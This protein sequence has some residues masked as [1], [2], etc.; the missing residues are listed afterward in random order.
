MFTVRISVGRAFCAAICSFAPLL[1]SAQ[2]A[3]VQGPVGQV[4]DADVMAD[5]ATR[6]SDTA[7][8]TVLSR[9]DNVGQLASN[10]YVQRAMAV[11]AERRGLTAGRESAAAL[12]LAREKAMADLYLAEFDKNHQPSEA[13][14]LAYAQSTY[15]AV[16][17]K[18]LD[19]PERTRVRHILL[20]QKSPETRARIEQILSDARAGKDFAQLAKD[21]SEDTGS[22]AQGGDI[23]FVT[24]G[25]TVVPFEEAMKGLKTPGD[26]SDVVE[27]QFGYHII[28]LEERRSAG[29]RGFDEVREQLLMQ[30]RT[31]LLR[32]A[33][34]KEA[35]RL[36][37]GMKVN[38]AAVNTFSSKF[39]PSD[40]IR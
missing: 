15:R 1:V 24:E 21:N 12:A 19:A 26:L 13:A 22:V 31:A 7:R 29:K 8:A 40:S 20:K 34:A 37:E 17:G 33:R 25:S 4:T 3:L 36:Q 6:I 2:Y 38:E 30:A 9:P 16:D 28:R 5:A 23:G 39:K 10:V 11:E 18:Q 35:Q 14:L 32:E 27:T